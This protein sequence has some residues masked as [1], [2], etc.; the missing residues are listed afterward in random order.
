MKV[1]K[2]YK[3]FTY[4]ILLAAL[5]ASFSLYLFTPTTLVKSGY[6]NWAALWVAMIILVTPWGSL[7]LIHHNNQQTRLRFLPWILRIALLE[8]A[9][10]AL[11]FGITQWSQFLNLPAGTSQKNLFLV[12][13]A[14]SMLHFG[15]FPWAIIAVFAVC[16]GI[17]AYVKQ[18]DSY[19]DT[20]VFGRYR[21]QYET[22]N[23]ILKGIGRAFTMT[24]LGIATVL[25]T[26]A[27]ASMISKAEYL[28]DLFGFN[29]AAVGAGLMLLMLSFRKTSSRLLAAVQAQRPTWGL[30]LNMVIWALFLGIYSLLLHNHTGATL[31]MPVFANALFYDQWSLHLSIFSTTWWFIVT[32][33]TA[34][35]IA[36]FS[37]GYSL[38]A[39]ILAT[40]ALPLLAVILLLSIQSISMPVNISPWYAQISMIIGFLLLLILTLNKKVL[41]LTAQTYLTKTNVV[42]HRSEI[43]FAERWKKTCGLFFYL[44]IP[45]GLVAITLLSMLTTVLAMLVVG[46]VLIHVVF[47]LKS[48]S[49]MA[50]KKIK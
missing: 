5:F 9:I 7:R 28:R 10:T 22:C 41:P 37:Y 3:H 26:I 39:V 20:L 19:L 17:T 33:L 44:F 38:R 24:A 16:F 8:I 21:K 29:L 50:S 45:G 49:A 23:V 47:L 18:Q 25:T 40:L 4:I 48:C 43:V 14:Q 15:L 1:L 42:K 34:L 32:P 30:L 46:L 35:F 36:R 27:I 12:N 11:Y 31:S 6:I 2:S 13:I